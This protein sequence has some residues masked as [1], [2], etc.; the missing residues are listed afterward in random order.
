M[1]RPV[2]VG[3]SIPK[4]LMKT[5]LLA[6]SLALTL[7]LPYVLMLTTINSCPS[8]VTNQHGNISC[9]S[10]SPT[11]GSEC[12]IVCSPH[13]LSSSSPHSSCTW[14]GG[15]SVHLE[16]GVECAPGVQEPGGCCHR[17]R[18]EAWGTWGTC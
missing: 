17:T 16:G 10:P 6:S 2:I 9:T 11:V 18:I 1:N 14:R 13:Y 12:S 15:W 5:M 8:L 7:A 4:S 3:P